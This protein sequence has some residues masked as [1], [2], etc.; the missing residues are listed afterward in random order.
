MAEYRR[1]GGWS[2]TRITDLLAAAVRTNPS[3]LAVV[4]A[5]NRAQLCGD[6][7]RR[8]SFLEL[9]QLAFQYLER[10]I[11][12]G[13]KRGH[14]LVTQLPNIAEYPALYMA[15]LQLGI[16]LSPVPIQY[17]RGDLEKIL[18]LTNAR[19]LITVPTFK[20]AAPA[21]DAIAASREQGVNVMVLGDVAPQGAQAL[22][23]RAVSAAK[24]QYLEAMVEASGIS[25]DDIATICWTSGTEGMPKGVPRSHNHWLAI[26]LVHLEGASIRR[27]D[28][29]LNPFPLVNMAALGGCFLSWLHAAGTLLLHHPFDLRIFLEQIGRDRPHYTV[30][31]PAV[32]NMLL[33]DPRLLSTTDLSSLRC[34]GS[35]SAPLDP[36]MIRAF[37]DRFGIEIVNMFGS[38]EGMALCS[39][40]VD[41]PDP[42]KRA[43]LFPRAGHGL[44]TRIVDPDNGEE[45]LEAARAGE[46]QIRG[47]SVFDGYFRAP[48]LTAA[49]FTQDGYFRTGDLFEIAE[50]GSE[51][52]YYR[53][54]GRLKQL[55][56]RGGMKIAPEEIEAVLA[57]HPDIAESS[58][59]PYR[60]P[61]MG[62]RVCAV[63]VPKQQ[64]QAITIESIQA[65]C[66][67][68]G[69]SIFKWPERVQCVASLPRNP[70]GKVVRSA[71]VE[72]L[73]QR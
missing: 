65:H 62:E 72:M 1:R 40:A 18:R 9:E 49:A 59:I 44:E 47:P 57:R 61:V 30:A 55:I 28:V 39:R 11:E 12:L 58:A 7:P 41:V 50:E 29:L 37:R 35:G 45:I 64:D 23:P 48:E 15:A 42:D 69:L 73:E 21:V 22:R 66:R 68:A 33:A 34:I 46:M 2:E 38:N 53:F 52:R 51:P 70:V 10:F 13:L 4:D 31:A 5:P 3:G 27:G 6:S 19:A 20:G 67:T 71:L 54:I 8:L 63:V 26:S 14:I 16:I 25:A 36:A 56:V 32:L 24:R 17:G 60:D 43:T